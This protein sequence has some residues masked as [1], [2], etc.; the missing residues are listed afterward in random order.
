V[1][2]RELF[3]AAAPAVGRKYQHI[4]DLVFTN[5]SVGGQ[6]AVERMR[7]MSQQGG[8]IEL[9]WDGSPVIY[10]GRDEAGRFMLIPKNAWDYL[11]RGK[12]ET[13]NGVSTVM[14][15][16]KDISNFILNTGKAEPVKEKQ[17]QGYANQLA[18]LWSYF[19]SI[20]PEKGF[21]E[22]GLLFYPGSKPD[23][24]SSMP[25]LN[26]KTKT[27][28]FKPNITT[29]HIPQDSDLGIKIKS[30]KVMVAAT[31]FYD[32]LGDGSESRYPNAEELSTAE[33]LV[34]GTTY[35][36]EAP[37][38]EQGDL[39]QAEQFIEQNAESIDSFIAGQPGLAKP[40][41][42]LYTFFNQNLRI[43]GVKSKFEQWVKQQFPTGGKAEKIL[44]HPGLNPTLDA[45]E[46]LT[47]AKM[48]LIKALNSGT[49]GGI[50]Q[51]K[52]EGYVQAHPGGEFKRDLPGQF[53]KT[54]DQGNWAPRKD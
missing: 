14:T 28:D 31:G 8:S 10:W 5:G 54:I 29:F 20:S 25:V 15:S 30:A 42:V 53:V 7:K 19:E 27:Y 4:E 36:Q 1:R 43:E 16:P 48:Q 17:R 35:V 41:D 2:L 45:V 22:G 18:S 21:I 50:K 13:T 12:K 26:P 6:H 3:E 33:V 52:P 51:T 44:K 34:Q 46:Y 32:S 37:Q 40:G 24:S 49:H 9:K 47:R 38:F 11:K 39:D 23:G